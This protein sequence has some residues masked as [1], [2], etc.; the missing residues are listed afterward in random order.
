GCLPSDSP[1]MRTIL[2]RRCWPRRRRPLLS[3]FSIAAK[4]ASTICVV[5]QYSLIFG[6]PG[7]PRAGRRRRISKLLGSKSRTRI[8]CFSASLS[9]TRKKIPAPFFKNSTSV[10]PTVG[11]KPER[12]PWTTASGAFLKASSSIPGDESFISMSAEFVPL[13]STLNWKKP[14]AVS[15][16]PRKARKITSRFADLMLLRFLLILYLL[17]LNSLLAADAVDIDEQTRSIAQELRCVVCQNLSVADSPS[18][19]AQQMR[20]VIREQLQAGKTSQEVKDFFV[21]KYGEWVLLSPTTKGFSLLLWALPFAVLVL[22]L[23]LALWLLRRWSA[24]KT[25]PAG[26]PANSELLTRVRND[27][28]TSESLA[29]DPEDSSPHAQLYQ[30]RARLYTELKELDFDYEAGKLAESDYAALRLDIENK[31][32]GVLQQ[33]DSL[34]SRRTPAR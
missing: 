8:W 12:S 3:L 33:L 5:K 6:P 22:G 29:I 34:P 4:S 13:W 30:E 14:P 28:N 25:K 20:G 10:I 7:A 9:K 21:S 1:A 27:A 2:P 16:A 32:A 11:M 17:P 15:S 31:A 26:S 18:E 23:C 24:N 19:M